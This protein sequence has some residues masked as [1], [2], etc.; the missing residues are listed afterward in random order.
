AME[1][2]DSSQESPGNSS[3][4]F[5]ELVLL[6]ERAGERHRERETGDD[7]VESR[8]SRALLL[9]FHH[10]LSPP[11]LGERQLNVT[12]GETLGGATMTVGG[13]GGDVGGQLGEAGGVKYNEMD[14]EFPH[15]LDDSRER[16][17]GMTMDSPGHALHHGHH[18]NEAALELGL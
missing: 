9:T 14:A 7:S 8:E 15:L 1:R 17:D 2:T 11:R 10:L 5:N 12:L 13:A 16:A 4:W 6:G 18:G 3:L